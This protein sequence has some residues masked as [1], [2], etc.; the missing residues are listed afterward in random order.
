MQCPH[1][2]GPRSP[3]DGLGAI[4][5]ET[6]A[7]VPFGKALVGG[8]LCILLENVCIA[9]INQ[10]DETRARAGEAMEM[11]ACLGRPWAEVWGD[12]DLGTHTGRVRLPLVVRLAAAGLLLGALDVHL[13]ALRDYMGRRSERNAQ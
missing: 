10:V 9:D 5:D 11:D 7:Q 8:Q 2:V 1:L 12:T 3:L 6:F 4:D 13:A